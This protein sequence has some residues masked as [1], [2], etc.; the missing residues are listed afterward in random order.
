MDKIERLYHYQPRFDDAILKVLSEFA[1]VETSPSITIRYAAGGEPKA[2]TMQLASVLLKAWAARNDGQS[3]KETYEQLAWV[4]EQ[5]FSLRLRDCVGERQEYDPR[6]H[7]FESG[8]APTSK[9]EVT[10][11]AVEGLD[12]AETGMVIK[13]LVKGVAT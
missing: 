8:E 5:F 4:L 9:V 7:E 6:F 11:P 10:R 13:A 2:G 3:S 1:D 12:P